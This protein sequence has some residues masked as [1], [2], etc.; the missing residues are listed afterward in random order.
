MK[1]RYTFDLIREDSF[2]PKILIRYA[3]HTDDKGD[4]F[5]T[6]KECRNSVKNNMLRDIYISNEILDNI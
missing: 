5:K 2:P 4:T 6:L 3:N 1:N